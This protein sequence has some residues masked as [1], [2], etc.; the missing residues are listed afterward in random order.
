MCGIPSITLEGTKADWQDILSRVDKFDSFGEEPTK[1]AGLLR[2]VLGRFVAAFDAPETPDRDFWGK[3]CHYESGGSGPDYLSGWI[4]AF[5][6]W[7]S[8]GKWQASHAAMRNS[9]LGPPQMATGSVSTAPEK[10]KKQSKRFSLRSLLPGKKSPPPTVAPSSEPATPSTVPTAPLLALD[11]TLYPVLASDDVPM[12]YCEVDV[13][14][15]DNGQEFKCKMLAGQMATKVAN[16][17]TVQS[18]SAW[19]MFVKKGGDA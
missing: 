11:E 10:S 3:I 6:V 9:M 8:K 19:F 12:G 4:T 2:P 14:L 18:G 16:K 7:S 17:T 1:W 15:D 13:K 5:C